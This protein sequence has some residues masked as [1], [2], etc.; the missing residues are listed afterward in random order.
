ME[1]LKENAMYSIISMK[2]AAT[3]IAVLL[4]MLYRNKRG[5]TLVFVSHRAI[6][7]YDAMVYNIM[8]EGCFYGCPIP[9]F[10]CG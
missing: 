3:G 7:A 9:N 10:V 8:F 1:V 6:D 5:F 4:I 2:C